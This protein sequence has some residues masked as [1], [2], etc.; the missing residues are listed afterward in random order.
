MYAI[1]ITDTPSGITEMAS[2][3]F[4]TIK[5]ADYYLR[6]CGFTGDCG[7]MYRNESENRDA[8]IV[9]ISDPMPMAYK[10]V[11]NGHLIIDLP[12]CLFTSNFKVFK[13]EPSGEFFASDPEVL[14][15]PCYSVDEAVREF[16]N[17]NKMILAEKCN[18]RRA[19][20]DS[21]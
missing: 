10:S 7:P 2:G 12:E 5:Q 11:D 21:D 20:G 4:E 15:G 14:V 1:E 17:F 18:A 13:N 16:E 9:K 3:R 19:N 8:C 6:Y